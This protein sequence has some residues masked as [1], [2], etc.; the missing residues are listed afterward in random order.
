[1]SMMTTLV[2]SKRT[3]DVEISYVER[4]DHHDTIVDA[5]D[6]RVGAVAKEDGVEDDVRT[7]SRVHHS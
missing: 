3:C 5:D 6:F 2:L 1:M 4:G 7:A